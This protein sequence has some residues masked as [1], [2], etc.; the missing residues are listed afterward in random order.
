MTVEERLYIFY[1]LVYIILCAIGGS[2]DPS[3]WNIYAQQIVLLWVL[4][5]ITDE[6]NDL[7]E[8]NRKAKS[9]S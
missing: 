9:K 7:I 1:S 2:I 8:K 6:I 4:Y 3:H 5:E